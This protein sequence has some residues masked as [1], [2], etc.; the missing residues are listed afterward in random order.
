M[1]ESA[2]AG[3]DGPGASQGE[4]IEQFPFLVLLFAL[5]AF[6]LTGDAF[7]DRFPLLSAIQ[8]GFER[9]RNAV[10]GDG[11]GVLGGIASRLE[12]LAVR[13]FLHGIDG[14]YAAGEPLF[15]NLA[16]LDANLV[17]SG[18]GGGGPLPGLERLGVPLHGEPFL[19]LP[20][21]EQC[22]KC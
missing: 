11:E 16:G 12:Q 20:N 2:N 9:E 13:L 15:E 8:H 21:G 5:M 7:L 22:L 18:Q 14:L 19:A 1:L 10:L 3:S 6:A 4:F 17:G